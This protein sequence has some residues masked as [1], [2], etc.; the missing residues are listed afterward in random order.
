MH[1]WVS[2]AT[3]L[4]LVC[5]CASCPPD[6]RCHDHDSIVNCHHAGVDRL[7]TPLPPSA[8]VLDGASGG[9]SV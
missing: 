5:A 7:P 4:L 6:C 9:R 3:T 8:I 2:V 1:R